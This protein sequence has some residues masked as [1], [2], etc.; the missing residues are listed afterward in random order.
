MKP[1]KF[2][3]SSHL[4]AGFLGGLT[5]A[6]CLQPLDLLKTRMQQSSSQSLVST[7]KGMA[8]PLELWRGTLPSAIRTSVGASLYLTTLGKMRSVL[9]ANSPKLDGYSSE[10]PRLSMQLN[11]ATGAVARGLVGF[12]TMPITVIKVRYES[13]FYHYRSL[14]DAVRSMYR[15]GG[16]RLFFA[17]YG[18]TITRDAPY[19]GLY[20]LFYEKCKDFLNVLVPAHNNSRSTT[21]SAALNSSA[22][23][24]S[25]SLATTV[26]APFDTI[27]TRVQLEPAKYKSFGPALRIIYR[28][29]GFFSLFDGLGLRLSRKALSAGV[30]W[31]IYEELVRRLDRK[32]RML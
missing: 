32:G 24:I 1:E 14:A 21:M 30:S 10:L 7:V 28:E 9:A 4:Y 13:S 22:A 17:G 15:E 12:I 29:S 25:A 16:I 18:V 6:V 19:A 5:S 23:A 31:C 2:K 27:K 20:V 3:T 26:T 11:L 8:S